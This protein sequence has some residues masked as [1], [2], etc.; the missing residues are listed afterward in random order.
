MSLKISW[1]SKENLGTALI[2][3]GASGL[4]QTLFILIAQ[5]GFQVGN[6]VAVI[7]VPIGVSLTLYLSL[8][9]TFEV[10]AQLERK[11]KILKPF[12]KKKTKKRQKI[13]SLFNNSILKPVLII[14]SCFTGISLATYA[15]SIILVN[16]FI[17]FLIAENL[18]AVLCIIIANYFEKYYAGIIKA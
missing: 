12:Q 9:V 16:S 10:F 11:A 13:K 15:I 1:K 5:Y 7:I 3:L 2:F 17:S 14:F 18:A 6:Y 4:L 8:I